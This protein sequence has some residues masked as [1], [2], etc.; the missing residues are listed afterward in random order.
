MNRY[1][2]G[3]KQSEQ[4]PRVMMISNSV[5]GEKKRARAPVSCSSR[6]GGN[7]FFLVLLYI[8]ATAS[9]AHCSTSVAQ[10]TVPAAVPER[11]ALV[12][13]PD[14][15][16]EN[17]TLTEDVTWRGTVLIRGYVVIA[18]QATVRIEPGTAVRFMKSSILRQAPRLVIMGRIQCS[19][20]VENPVVFAPNFAESM[21]GDWGG[22]M[23][24]STE[25]R[26]QFEQVRIEG[27]AT[28]IDARFSNLNG[29]GITIIRS[30]TG[31]VLKDSTAQ[32]GEVS[33]SEC[34]TGLDIRDSEFELRDSTVFANQTGIFAHHASLVFASLTLRDNGQQ[35]IQ[36]E[37][38]RIRFSSC[39]ISGNG[40]GA[41]VKGGEGQVLLSRFLR[42]R[43]AGIRMDG[44]RLRIYRSLFADNV[45]DGIRAEDGKS[46]IWGCSFSGNG[47]A[48][49]AV[50][51]GERISAVL[52]WWGTAEE[53]AI[54]SKLSG[55]VIVAPWLAEKP[56]AP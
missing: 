43:Q 27:A 38:C 9:F 4:L 17:S 32:L 53:T 6:I 51:G 48:N 18:P 16:Y 8:M 44:A 12:S 34:E 21:P 25:K 5:T 28:G 33:V 45:R 31:V 30:G 56:V 22:I 19:G 50:S 14:I 41:L 7:I 54:T 36:A 20:A 29:K 15:S 40:V 42:N 35:G 23:L 52:N 3:A 55:Q 13:Q 37:E 10:S 47:G 1:T 49:L 24:L 39:E 26:N 46:I 11:K 2:A